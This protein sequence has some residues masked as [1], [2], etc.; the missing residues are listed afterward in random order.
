MNEIRGFDI[1]FPRE[2]LRVALI[3]SLLS[4]WVLVGLFYYLNR[5]TK[6]H[7]FTVWTAAWLF[8]AL[9]L[10]MGITV[11][12]ATSPDSM[13]YILRQWCVS[14]SA[15]FLLWG[16][17]DFLELHA[18]QSL[19]GLFIAFLLTWSYAGRILTHDPFYIQIPIFVLIGLASMFSGLSFYRLR[20]DR[21]FVAVGMLFLG[22]C[23]W[24]LYLITYPFSQKFAMLF[25]AGF[26]FSAVLQL[27]IAV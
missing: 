8:Y 18:P 20:R 4:V 13:V 6:R 27:F 12:N 3:V 19:F 7:Y 26:L 5:Y 2:Y 25:N 22:F 24:G 23:L 15:V 16:S 17:L 9:W 21:Q 11:P 14:I 1:V 10:T